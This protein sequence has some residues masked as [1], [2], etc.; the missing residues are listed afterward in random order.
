MPILNLS[1]DP[2]VDITDKAPLEIASYQLCLLALD[3]IAS[4]DPA[5]DGTYQ[6]SVLVSRYDNT[7]VVNHLTAHKLG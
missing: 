7:V 3:S 6:V 1:F 2:Q 4:A 5:D